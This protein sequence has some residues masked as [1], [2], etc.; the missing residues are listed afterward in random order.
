MF[1]YMLLLLYNIYVP[2]WKGTGVAQDLFGAVLKKFGGRKLT[3]R[4][5]RRA[6]SVGHGVEV[7]FDGETIRITK[8]GAPRG[9]IHTSRTN[10]QQLF[11]TIET[12]I[13]DEGM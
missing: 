9:C 10:Q 12:A 8:F 13:N 4:G 1:E 3:Q 11:A 5:D 7:V 6:I 2:S